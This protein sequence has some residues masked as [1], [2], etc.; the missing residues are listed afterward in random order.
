MERFLTTFLPTR[1]PVRQIATF[2]ALFALLGLATQTSALQATMMTKLP[3]PV[4]H[5]MRAAQD[6]ILI[7]V[8]RRFE[9]MA[10]IDVDDPRSRRS[11]K[12]P[13]NPR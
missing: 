13:K 11:D 4:A 12:L 6:A 10:W 9:G 5:A 2:A 3:A 7:R 8:S 1:W